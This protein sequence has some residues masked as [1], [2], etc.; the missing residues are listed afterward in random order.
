MPGSPE[1]IRDEG[2]M[3]FLFGLIL[4]II[5][6]L[7]WKFGSTP[8][9][10]G[11]IIPFAVV[12]IFSI[13]GGLTLNFNNQHRIVKYQQD[14]QANP[15]KFIESEKERTEGFIKWYT[16]TLFSMAGLIIIGLVLFLFLHSPNWK[17]V[18]LGLILFGFS[19]IYLDHFSEERAATYRQKIVEELKSRE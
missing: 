8:Y 12:A 18:G 2:R 10:R 14:Y 5:S 1:S 9:A 7:Y 3:Y 13:A 19:V 16:Y 17:G 6:I 11:V 15:Q 4:L